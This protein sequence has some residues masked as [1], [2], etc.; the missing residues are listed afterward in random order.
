MDKNTEATKN[1]KNKINLSSLYT[2]QEI[3][4]IKKIIPKIKPLIISNISNI[5]KINKYSNQ[6]PLSKDI[7]QLKN[8]NQYI[9][10]QK[11]IELILEKAQYIFKEENNIILT[12]SISYILEE[13]QKLLDK[14][15]NKAKIEYKKLTKNSISLKFDENK[16]IK[17]NNQISDRINQDKNK[18]NIKLSSSKSRVSSLSNDKNKTMEF[19]PFSPN[20]KN[21][22]N[23]N[24]YNKKINYSLKKEKYNFS[25]KNGLNINNIKGNSIINNFIT[26]SNSNRSLDNSSYINLNHNS[27]NNTKIDINALNQILCNKNKINYMKSRLN[28]S[29]KLNKNMIK[30]LLSPKFKKIQLNKN[31]DMINHFSP[32]NLISKYYN[33]YNTDRLLKHAKNTMS[34][35]D[36][37]SFLKNNNN[38]LVNYIIK[39]AKYQTENN[40]IIKNYTFIQKVK[41]F[42][43]NQYKINSNKSLVN[44][45]KFKKE[46]SKKEINKKEINKKEINKKEINKKDLININIILYSN[47]EK[48]DFDIFDFDYKVGKEY[49]LL[50]IGNYI[51]KKLSFS[52]IIKLDK[53]HNWCRK[54][55]AGYYRNNPYHNDLH[56]SDVAQTTFIY[57]QYGKIINQI[58]LNTISTCSIILSCLCHDYKHPGVNNIF[59]KETKNEL[60]FLYN[61][62]SVLENM[63][64]SETFKLINTNPDC[65]I[66]SGVDNNIYKEIRKQMISC[67]LSTDMI[68]H[69]KHIEFMKSIIEKKRNNITIKNN[70]DNLQ[71]MQLIIHSADISNPTKPFDIYLKW[72]KLVLEEFM[73]QGD[74]EKALGLPCSCDRTK[75]QLNINQ[76]SFIDYIIESYV[77]LYVTIFPDLQFLYD[78][79]INNREKFINYNEDNNTKN[80]FNNNNKKTNQ[81]K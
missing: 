70:N 55:A 22:K 10:K 59:L 43:K 40:S 21:S 14:T 26:V 1:Y 18:F 13:I 47:I 54:I 32:S 61:D 8:S 76:I 42:K 80:F 29:N 23:K 69:T 49:T 12:K 62:L 52:S 78:N 67:V 6:S 73:Q 4:D 37:K 74:K 53:Y 30:P 77:S 44:Q 57:F 16:I 17:R 38:Y 20:N 71:Y 34:D 58:Q 64:I 65:N 50:L 35:Y 39:S 56:A 31:N 3:E 7:F 19:I 66:F 75:V 9:D 51:Y 11:F 24:I 2:N 28:T 41:S 27:N 25:Y 46:I 72:S 33:S 48:K 45:I 15:K 60:S 63:H 81:K 68:N 79:V 36:L 5:N